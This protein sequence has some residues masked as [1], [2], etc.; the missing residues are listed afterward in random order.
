MKNKLKSEK[1]VMTAYVTVVAVTF[2]IILSAIFSIAVSNRKNQ[3]S[4]LIKIKEVYEQGNDS[5]EQLYEQQKLKDRISITEL[6]T[7]QKENVIAQDEFGNQ[8]V[9]PG[10]FKLA[11]DSGTNVKDGIVIEDENENQFVWIP[12]SNIDGKGT[13]RIRVDENTSLELTLG[14]YEF[15]ENNN[16]TIVQKGEEYKETSVSNANAGSIGMYKIGNYL[17]VKD[18][19]ES[20]YLEDDNAENATAKDME[21]FTTSVKENKGYYIARYEASY[22]SGSSI[23]NWKP[24]SKPS[25]SYD[26]E[27]MNY[28]EGTLWNFI[29]QGDAAKVC[30]N[31]Y[32][33]NKFVESDLMNSYALDTAIIYIQEM[34]N[35]DYSSKTDGNMILRN[36]GKTDDKVCNIYDL[37]GNTAEWNTEY[38]ISDDK[39]SPATC[40]GGS[41][42]TVGSTSGRGYDTT[43]AVYDGISFRPILYIK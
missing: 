29:N 41:Y 23:M 37:S 8:V 2:V 1:G 19:R 26:K 7:I 25:T 39:K 3:I 17:E 27:S 12:V 36:T 5:A 22:G 42:N 31:M 28:T 16:S 24:L 40:R 33:N 14:R 43:T 34:G 35:I 15:K 4:T 30:R 38:H 21:K 10:G 11:E 32:S 20:N 13:N 9:V 18:Y 6:T